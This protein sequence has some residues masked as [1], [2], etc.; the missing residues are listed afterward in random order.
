MNQKEALQHHLRCD[1]DQIKVFQHGDR[2]EFRRYYMCDG[3][4]ENEFL[5]SFNPEFGDDLHDIIQILLEVIGV[6][7]IDWEDDK[8]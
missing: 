6:D 7:E 5:Y 3:E 1:S 4:Q 8:Q 2:Y